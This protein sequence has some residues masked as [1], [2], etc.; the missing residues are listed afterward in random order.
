MLVVA[1]ALVL[2]VCLQRV[3]GAMGASS[4]VTMQERPGQQ[5]SPSPS[6]PPPTASQDMAQIPARCGTPLQALA[7]CWAQHPQELLAAD[8][9]LG[10]PV[11]SDEDEI[12]EKL[13]LSCLALG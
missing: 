13:Q 3:A 9:E 4:T 10:A 12:E 11:M 8:E 1:G 5:M 2:G 6:R 7:C